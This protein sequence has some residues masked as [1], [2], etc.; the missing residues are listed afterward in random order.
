MT[1]AAALRQ[2]A[3]LAEA[4]A[5]ST[6]VLISLDRA[7]N[8]Y[9]ALA[10]ALEGACFEDAQRAARLAALHRETER[11]QLKFRELLKS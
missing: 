2:V 6:G 4:Q 7:A 3:G 10:L 5:E 8:F 1:K 11:E 9:D